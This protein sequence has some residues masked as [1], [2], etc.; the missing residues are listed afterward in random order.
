[1]ASLLLELIIL[2]M[3]VSLSLALR[4]V[5][6]TQYEDSIGVEIWTC[7]PNKKNLECVGK[8]EHQTRVLLAL[9]LHP[10]CPMSPKLG[11]GIFFYTNGA[12]MRPSGSMSLQPRLRCT[13]LVQRLVPAL[14]RADDVAVGRLK[15]ITASS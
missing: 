15:S 9:A 2:E 14:C 10:A 1:V 11:C 6:A 8:L 13:M 12:P 4:L 5:T 3:Q 7:Q